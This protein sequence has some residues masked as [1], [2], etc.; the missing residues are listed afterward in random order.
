MLAPT[1]LAGQSLAQG[2]RTAG[3]H[4]VPDD[5]QVPAGNKVFLKGAADGTQNYI[6][7]PSGSPCLDILRAAGHLVQSP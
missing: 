2:A 6:C 3:A 5:V 4:N 1:F 7:L